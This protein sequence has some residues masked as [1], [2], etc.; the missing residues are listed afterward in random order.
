MAK[1]LPRQATSIYA[2][3]TSK[4][5]ALQ[6]MPLPPLKHILLLR[7]TCSFAACHQ[8][9][10]FS[11]AFKSFLS[12]LRNLLFMFLQISYKLRRL[13]VLKLERDKYKCPGM[14]DLYTNTTIYSQMPRWLRT[15]SSVGLVHQHHHRP[16][17][18]PLVDRR[19]KTGVP[20]LAGICE[21]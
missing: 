18:R 2:Y 4:L 11:G 16:R 12:S 6:Q 5:Y 10:V 20:V 19:R 8:R 14:S 1:V 7:I 17:I 3:L 15:R 9:V 21:Q 13:C